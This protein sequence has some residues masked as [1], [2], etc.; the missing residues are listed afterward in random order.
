MRII[1]L[2]KKK[3]IKTMD[4]ANY[5]RSLS[6]MINHEVFRDCNASCLN[7]QT[8]KPAEECAKNC[9]AKHAQ[10]MSEFDFTIKAELPK[11]QEASRII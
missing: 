5:S 2:K 3:L 1:I 7:Y 11:L 10:Y 6:N 8:G 9:S 4:L